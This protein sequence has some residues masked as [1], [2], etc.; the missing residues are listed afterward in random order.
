M[1]IGITEYGDAGVDLRWEN[2]LT[3]LDG[4]V[5]ITKNI[6]D[7]FINAAMQHIKELPIIVHCT[8]TGWG[9]SVMEP[10][11]PDYKTQLNQL[12]KLIQAGFPAERTVLRVD[13]IF[14]T[15]NGINRVLEMLCY[16][17]SLHLP[18]NKIRYRM[19]IVDEYPH[20][21]ERYKK[22]GFTPM[23]N[24][25]FSPSEEQRKLVATALT[26]TPYKFDTCA[27][28]TL[29]IRFPE[30]F[31]IRGCIS[32]LDLELMGIPYDD[33]M[34][35]NPQKRTGCHCL[36]CKT[37]LLRPRQKCPHNCLY[38]FWKD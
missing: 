13:P 9:S 10:N 18:E 34:Y 27:E 8:C 26:A 5:L 31:R 6:T 15:E 14:P 17:H 11:V 16:Y 28:D 24:G 38:C 19:S 35:E 2:K 7:R 20:V 22:L 29:A 37:E 1:K 30:T 4:V 3:G 33:T 32:Q 25:R 23:Y 36:S 12:Q 21:R